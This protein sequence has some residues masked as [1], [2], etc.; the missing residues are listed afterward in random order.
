MVNGRLN[1]SREQL[2]AFLKDHQS[3]KQFEQ[4]FLTVDAIAPDFVNEVYIAAA[5]A[6]A[7]AQMALSLIAAMQNIEEMA[8]KYTPS[9][10]RAT[11]SNRVLIW[12]ST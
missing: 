6:T 12:L 1:L 10:D 5:N 9:E 3:I 7:Q 11:K 4:L 2:A 8:P